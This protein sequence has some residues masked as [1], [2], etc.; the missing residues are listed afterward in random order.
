MQILETVQQNF[1]KLSIQQFFTLYKAFRTWPNKVRLLWHLNVSLCTTTNIKLYLQF[2]GEYLES[3]KVPS[4]TKI[5]NSTC[6][7]F[8]GE[9]VE[10][11]PAAHEHYYLLDFLIKISERYRED[12]CASNFVLD[13]VKL[14]VSK[15]LGGE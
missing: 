12:G 1:G 14:G 13:L 11:F 9:V 2:V 7:K 5:N 10:M 4:G 15:L 3:Y 8:F 6:I